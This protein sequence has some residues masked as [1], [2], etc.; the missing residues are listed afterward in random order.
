MEDYLTNLEAYAM[1]HENVRN[2]LE[3][4]K[5]GNYSMWELVQSKDWAQWQAAGFTEQ[6]L[7]QFLQTLTTMDWDVDNIQ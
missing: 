5:L 6:S 7:S 4:I 1:A 2:A 3:K